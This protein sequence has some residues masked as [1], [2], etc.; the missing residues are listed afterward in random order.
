MII[1]TLSIRS[2]QQPHLK[3]A[4]GIDV[5]KV[6]VCPSSTPYAIAAAVAQVSNQSSDLMLHCMHAQERSPIGPPQT[7]AAGFSKPNGVFAGM[8]VRLCV[9]VCV[10]VRACV[11]ACVCVRVRV[12]VR[13]RV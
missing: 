11:R 7:K 12:R 8:L 6:C 2:M 13:V 4:V 1:V 9:C 3:C 5:C 10:C